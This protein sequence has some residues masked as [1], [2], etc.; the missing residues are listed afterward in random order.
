MRLEY[1]LHKNYQMVIK[2]GS[3]KVKLVI[4][5]YRFV[6]LAIISFPYTYLPTVKLESE[7]MIQK[8]HF[9]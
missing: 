2:Y 3:F 6:M 5:D 7:Q 9:M 4:R 1:K 8:D